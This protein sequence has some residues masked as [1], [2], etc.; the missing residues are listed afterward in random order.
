MSKFAGESA[1]LGAACCWAFT[2]I[3]FTISGT[4]V[5]AAVVNRVRLVMALVL[6]AVTHFFVF[7][8]IFPMA[9]DSSRWFWL[10]LS[11]VVGLAFG[12]GMLFQAFV[13]I[14]ARISMLLM[15]LVPVIGTVV[16]WFFLGERLKLWEIVG[17][18]VTLIGITAVIADK[19][20]EPAGMVQGV[21][22]KG[23]L[24]GIGGA[25]GQAVGLILSKKGMEGAFP[26]LSANMIRILVAVLVLWTIEL[27]AGSPKATIEK[28][29]DRGAV[30]AMTGG[31][32]F[33][34][35]IGIWLS[36]VA[37]NNAPIGIAST[38]MALTP[39]ILLP[40]VR[41][42]FKEKITLRALV[43]TIVAV[44]GVCLLVYF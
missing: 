15:A 9:A 34:P 21:K 38:L 36:L 17:I 40:V 33:G 39:I 12:D 2:S 11:G 8:E 29:K 41:F 6:L 35:F 28:L 13:A 22:S 16:A 1:A 3:L 19:H 7:G 24:F 14:G 27:A 31:A 43:G 42:V 20:R 23:I 32:V 37:I 5:G 10:G 30:L 26:P 44:A 18:L 4:R 25:L